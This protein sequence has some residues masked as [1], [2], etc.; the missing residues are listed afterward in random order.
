MTLDR[1]RRYV[2]SIAPEKWPRSPKLRD[3]LFSK[4]GQV[5][6]VGQLDQLDVHP[7]HA[8]LAECSYR[9]RQLAGRS[10]QGMESVELGAQPACTAVT[11]RSSRPVQ[12]GYETE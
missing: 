9:I 4:H 8:R 6:Q 1:Y 5:V 10:H 7:L 2:T 3:D 11:A 12:T